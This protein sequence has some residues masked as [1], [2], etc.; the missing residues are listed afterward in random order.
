MET[1]PDAEL[2][3]VDLQPSTAKV[4]PLSE[5]QKRRQQLREKPARCYSLL[6]PHTKVPDPISKRLEIS[7]KANNL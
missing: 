2:F 7:D 1:L 5:K 4:E 6:L 3:H